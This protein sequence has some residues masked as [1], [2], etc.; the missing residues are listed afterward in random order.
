MIAANE[1]PSVLVIDDELGPRESI[2]MLLKGTH[3]VMCVDSVDKG[4]DLLKTEHPDLVIT[5]IRMPGKDGIAG[6]REIRDI[7]PVVSVIIL[8]GHGSLETARQALRLGATDYIGKPFDTREMTAIVNRY[9]DRSRLERRRSNM[10]LELEEVN[11]RLID[12]LADKEALALLGRSSAEFAHDLRNPLMIVS[13]YVDL[14]SSQ[15][16][17]A[18]QNNGAEYEQAT[19]YL[20]VIEQNVKRCCE[21]SHMWQKMG[22]TELDRVRP[23]V[24][25]EILDTLTAAVEPLA[26]THKVAIRYDYAANGTIIRASGPQ[27][28]R[29]LY[30]VIANAVQAVKPPDGRVTVCCRRDGDKLLI[31]VRDNGCGMPHDVLQRI[32]EPYFT[33]KTEGRGTGLGMAIAKRIT[34]EHGG[35]IEVQSAVGE[36]TTVRFAFP[37]TPQPFAGGVTG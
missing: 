25:S 8:T 7:D 35:R 2:R 9:V 14:L 24:V 4:L 29:A 28:I 32:F 13:G 27:L 18:K 22:R 33:T 31:A 15:L 6:L 10:L 19:E 21:L 23:T 17:N 20:D 36:G 11:R 26:S 16:A 34:E 30:N 37:L 3:K 12:D 5:D 1:L